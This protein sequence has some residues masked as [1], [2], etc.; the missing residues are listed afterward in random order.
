MNKLITAAIV[1]A[2]GVSLTPAAFAQGPSEEKK[3]LREEIRQEKK[4]FRQ[5]VKE[6]RKEMRQEVK[7]AKKEMRLGLKELFKSKNASEEAKKKGKAGKITGGTITAINGSSFTVS[8]DSV[9]ITVNSSSDTKFNR[10][11]WGKSSLS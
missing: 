10:H 2:L 6:E 8:K 4:E 5:T 9:T 3:A 11:F 1:L 7:E